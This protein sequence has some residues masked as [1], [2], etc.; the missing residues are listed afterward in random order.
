MSM[1]EKQCTIYIYYYTETLFIYLF[2]YLFADMTMSYKLQMYIISKSFSW[3]EYNLQ[4]FRGTYCLFWLNCG[5]NHAL[6][7]SE[8]VFQRYQNQIPAETGWYDFPQSL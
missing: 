8:V 3:F 2:V 7:I 6:D 1:V 4:C 5:G